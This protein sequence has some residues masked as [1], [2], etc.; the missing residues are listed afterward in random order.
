MLPQGSAASHLNDVPSPSLCLYSS[1][2]CAFPAPPPP[3]SLRKQLF[4]AGQPPVLHLH[5]SLGQGWQ[6][7]VQLT[8]SS[9]PQ[10]SLSGLH[11]SLA[12][13]FFLLFFFPFASVD[14]P[15]PLFLPHLV[16]ALPDFSLYVLKSVVSGRGCGADSASTIHE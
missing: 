6:L 10:L 11:L 12:Q 2:A 15:T 4:M 5:Q 8:D 16:L 3:R 1:S 9:S 7:S 14:S 13:L